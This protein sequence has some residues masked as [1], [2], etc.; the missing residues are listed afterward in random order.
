M[1]VRYLYRY[2][3]RT[4]GLVA[5]TE[6]RPYGCVVALD[7]DLIGATFVDDEDQFTKSDAR[8]IAS[9]R[10]ETNFIPNVS[11]TVQTLYGKR[12][13]R[14]ELQHAIAFVREAAFNY[15][16]DDALETLETFEIYDDTTIEFLDEPEIVHGSLVKK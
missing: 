1:I 13:I 3:L 16:I 15:H 14:D 10:A 9:A 2:K 6:K 12:K 11:G 4:K 8:R 5:W 7:Y